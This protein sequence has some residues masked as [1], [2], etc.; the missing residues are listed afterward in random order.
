[1]STGVIHPVQPIIKRTTVTIP[2]ITIGANGYVE[3]TQYRPSG[4]AVFHV[5]ISTWSQ[6]STHDAFAVSEYGTY[7]LG[8][9]GA[10][11]TNLELV[12]WYT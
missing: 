5:G 12:Y 8:T 11:I 2:S 10:V 9:A 6:N 7:L 1:M 4:K 3:I